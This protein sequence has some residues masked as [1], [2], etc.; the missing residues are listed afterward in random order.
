MTAPFKRKRVFLDTEVF[1]TESFNFSSTKL[2]A[3]SCLASN[4]DIN[5]VTTS[6]TV[7]E[8]KRRIH[9]MVRAARN[10]LKDKGLRFEIGILQQTSLDCFFLKPLDADSLATEV[11]RKFDAYLPEWGFVNQPDKHGCNNG[12]IQKPLLGGFAAL[13]LKF[14]LR[15]WTPRFRANPRIFICIPSGAHIPRARAF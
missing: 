4:G 2:A 3:L 12:Q 13:M 14:V 5:V 11:E 7:K 1:V 9:K 8:C 15:F 6:V 10:S